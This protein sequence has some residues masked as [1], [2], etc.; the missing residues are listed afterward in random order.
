MGKYRL[1]GMCF[2][3]RMSQNTFQMKMDQLVKLYPGTL[4]IHC[5]MSI[6]S[7]ESM[8]ATCKP[9]ESPPKMALYSKM[10]SVR[11]SNHRPPIM[12]TFSANG[13]KPSPEIFQQI[14][15]LSLL[16]D[17]QSLQLFLDIIYFMQSHTLHP[18]HPTT[19]L[20]ELFK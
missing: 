8:T 6:G 9:H 18:S 10:K 5:H 16:M 2:G 3:L 19:S 12:G 1:K 14:T 17:F 7:Q 4:C 13:M 15:K 20:Y 11:S